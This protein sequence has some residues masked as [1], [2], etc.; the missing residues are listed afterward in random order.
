MTTIRNHAAIKYLPCP[1]F[2]DLPYKN[3]NDLKLVKMLQIRSV[4]FMH[5]HEILESLRIFRF[6]FPVPF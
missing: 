5:D 1:V 3:F 6:N 2:N 4:N